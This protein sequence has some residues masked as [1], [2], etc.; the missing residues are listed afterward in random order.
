MTPSEVKK[1]CAEV[2]AAIDAVDVPDWRDPLQPLP[3]RA[4]HAIAVAAGAITAMRFGGP[5]DAIAEQLIEAADA[6]AEAVPAAGMRP[7]PIKA[8]REPYEVAAE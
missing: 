2:L 1:A 8:E 3:A 7:P 5:P 6:Y 4:R